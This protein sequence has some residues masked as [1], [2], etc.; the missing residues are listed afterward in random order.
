M[1]GIRKSLAVTGLAVA[2]T[3]GVSGCT[4]HKDSDPSITVYDEEDLSGPGY[5]GHLKGFDFEY[6]A[7]WVCYANPKGNVEY[8]DSSGNALYQL[9]VKCST[10]LAEGGSIGRWT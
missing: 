10:V 5:V 3:I 8:T 9:Y 1:K 2:L 4:Q 6:S 7:G